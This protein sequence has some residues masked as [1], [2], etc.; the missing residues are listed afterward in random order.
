M[1]L[2]WKIDPPPP[3]Q[4]TDRDVRLTGSHLSGKRVALLITGS[5]A[6]YRMP[7]LVRDFRRE[8]ADVVVYAT[9]EGL[10]YVAKEALEWCSQNPV[11]DRFTSEA[12][13]LS[14][15]TP[16]DVFVVAPASYNILNKAALGIA[17]CVV[18]SAIAAAL[19]R[20]ERMGIPLLFAPAMHGSMHNK[21]LTR[22]MQTLQE[23]GVSLIPPTQAHGKNNLAS[24]DLIVAATIRSLSKS[25]LFG[26]SLLITGGPT[27]VPL[28]NIRSI[29]TY[30]T[31]TLSIKIAREAWLRGA[32]V[33]LI[34]G[35]GSR[36]APDFI[37]TK[38]AAT[39]EDY[40]SILKKSLSQQS[41]DWGI[42]TAAVAD[43]QPVK[44]YKGKLSSRIKQLDLKLMPT[45]KM[46]DEVRKKYPQLK[47]VTFKYEE[48]VSHEE[49]MK[50]AKK[51]FSKK[52]GPQMVVAN[53]AEEFKPDGTQVAWLI[54]PKNEPEKHVG[55]EDIANAILKRVEL[56]S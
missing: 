32:S 44:V 47:T 28:D 30:F 24:L 3:S 19:G 42:F 6:A 40:A 48:N 26:K 20:M 21:I 56:N 8:G 45:P 15:V 53:R 12:E 27:P 36:S 54:Q 2:E 22:S 29:T 51:P 14:D 43:F 31:G 49:L 4:L 18:S 11:I 37:N 1:S 23:M 35:K 16:F 46:V 13:H 17:D 50:I 9:N 38:I 52:G 55:K 10:R 41:F 5:I 25:S 33:E 39:F 34:L 7:D